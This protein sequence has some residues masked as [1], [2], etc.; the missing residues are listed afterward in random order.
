MKKIYTLYTF[1]L[2]LVVFVNTNFAQVPTYTLEAKNG[3]RVS[4]T[5]YTFDMVFTHTDAILMQ[6]AGWQFFFRLDQAF[7]DVGTGTGLNSSFYYDSTGGDAISDLPVGFRPR[8]PQAVIAVNAPGNYELRLAANSLPG[9]GNGLVI[10]QGVPTLIGRYKIITTGPSNPAGA[11]LRFRDSCEVPLSVTRTKINWYDANDCLNKEMTR[12]VSHSVNLNPVNVPVPN[13]LSDKQIIFKGQSINFTD[14]SNNSPTGWSWTF[15]GGTPSSSNVQ[16]PSGIVYNS[17]GQFSVSLQASNSFGNNSITK[18]N[19]ITVIE[20]PY[21]CPYT[22]LSK[23][24][25]TDAANRTDTVTFGMSPNGS[26]GIDTCLGEYLLPPPP[27]LGIFDFRIVLPPTYNKDAVKSDFRQDQLSNSIYWLNFQ[28]SVS[29]PITFRWDPSSFPS[30]GTFYLRE[31]IL[32]TNI[33]MKNQN[34]F[35]LSNAGIRF[36]RIDYEFR[37]NYSIDVSSNWNLIS[38]PLQAVDMSV[39]S[40]FE[41]DVNTAYGYNN[42]YINLSNLSNGNGYWVNFPNARSYNIS[43]IFKYPKDINVINGW[44][45]VGPFEEEIPVNEIVS[46]PSGLFASNFYGYNNGY[47]TEDTLEP[48]KGYWIKTNSAG[49]FMKDTVGS[50]NQDFTNVQLQRTDSW[51]RFEISDLNESNTTLYLAD[52][53]EINM[54]YDLPPVPPAGIF[55]ARFLTDRSVEVFGIDQNIKIN[56]TG[57]PLYFTASNLKGNSI[58]IKDNIDGSILN[59]LLKEDER[60]LLNNSLDNYLIT[61]EKINPDKY[62]LAQNYPNPFNPSTKINYSIPVTGKVQLIIYNALGQEVKK[63][64]NEIQNAGSYNVKFNGADLS[65]GIYFYRIESGNFKEI[66]SMVLIK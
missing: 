44:N 6:L 47:I 55:D 43:G 11:N 49:K 32:G 27:P 24:T 26:Y 59:V 37:A 61:M 50:L 3:V 14:I 45:M 60:I 15:P 35:V 18:T 5:V 21:S 7:G 63:L 23:I 51:V 1:I 30:T 17:S 19:Y 2:L 38:I 39:S 53:N 10:P 42:G 65:S 13:F 56:S 33:N 54:N 48:G 29:G 52:R 22:W 31:D 46:Y 34:S 28:T 58:R 4:P 20:N 25:A 66:R 57:Q 8:N 36:L 9:C 41:S 64:V 12:C 40:L 62:E 16:N